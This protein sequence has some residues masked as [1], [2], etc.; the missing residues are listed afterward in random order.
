[1][2]NGR[3]LYR[4]LWSYCNLKFSSTWLQFEIY[5]IYTWPHVDFLLMGR[6]YID[7]WFGNTQ[8]VAKNFDVDHFTVCRIVQCFGSVA[9]S[10]YPRK[11][12]DRKLTESVKLLI[13][14][15]GVTLVI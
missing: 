1:M 2:L 14:L 15:K 10:L 6:T 5:T 4:D 11:K 13:L 9:K 7:V 8:A 12:A 3:L